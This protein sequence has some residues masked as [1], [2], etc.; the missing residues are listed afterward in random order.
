[1]ADDIP[2]F[3][4]D[5]E[6]EPLLSRPPSE[7]EEDRRLNVQRYKARKLK[8]KRD[9][10]VSESRPGWWADAGIAPVRSSVAPGTEGGDQPPDDD[11]DDE[12][13]DRDPP[14]ESEEGPDEK[15]E[16]PS[17]DADAEEPPDEAEDEP[18]EERLPR[19]ARGEEPTDEE[20]TRAGLIGG[21]IEQDDSEGIFFTTVDRRKFYLA[22][23]GGSHYL[24]LYYY[25]VP[26]DL[27]DQE[28][29]GWVKDLLAHRAFEYAREE[30]LTVIPQRADISVD[31]LERHP[32][33]RKD[34]KR[35]SRRRSAS[36][37]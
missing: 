11:R 8:A 3:T 15:R 36:T 26:S 23:G 28:L 12:P 30:G 10:G 29:I 33:Y 19:E 17:D 20:L 32:E 35:P 5:E 6:L 34:V 2:G 24:T 18:A 4:P 1:M 13:A 37:A 31:F 9:A 7:L 27:D 21:P 14:E 16:E 25:Q 22:Y